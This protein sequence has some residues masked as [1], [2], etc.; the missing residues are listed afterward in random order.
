MKCMDLLLK[1][2]EIQWQGSLRATYNKYLHPDVLDYVNPK[3]WDDMQNGRI[4]SL[5][6]FDT[7]CGSVCIKRTRPNSVAELGAANAVM[8]LMGT[9]GEERPLDRY[10]R[11][12]DNINEWYKEMDEA[13]LTPEEQQVLKEEL[14]SKY[15]N[16]VEQEDMM[17]L[18]QRPEIAN[19][20]LGEANLLRKAVA[21]KDAKKIEKMKKRFFEAVDEGGE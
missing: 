2:G 11:F 1:A 15:G 13:G 21:K 6:Q 19:F 3:M 5:F 10:V 7:Q 18:V 14:L 8:R 17:R 16:S 9:E 4:F 20:T 12:R